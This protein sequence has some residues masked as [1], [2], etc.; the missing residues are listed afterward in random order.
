MVDPQRTVTQQR[1]RAY[2]CHWLCPVCSQKYPGFIPSR[3]GFA[4]E[5]HLGHL[6]RVQ[7][8]WQP[9]GLRAFK[10]SES[11]LQQAP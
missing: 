4:L 9:P 5:R 2:G 10:P 11:T 7:V 3:R 1:G 8:E 6:R